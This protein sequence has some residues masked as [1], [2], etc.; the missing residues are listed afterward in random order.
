MLSAVRVVNA[1]FT[2]K[3]VTKG[4]ANPPSASLKAADYSLA[5][6]RTVARPK[7]KREALRHLSKR[8][9][10]ANDIAIIAGSDLDE[11]YITNI[12]FGNQN[13][14]AIVDTGSSDSWLAKKGF[15]CFTLAD[16]PEPEAECAFGTDGFDPDASPT[17]VAYPGHNFNISYGD[18]EFLT[19]EVGFETVA[20]GG[21][22]V[23]SQEVGIVTDAAWFGDGES[24]GLIGLCYPDLTSVYSTT[25]PSD[26]SAANNEPYD[27]FVFSAIKQGLISDP[28]FSVA[29]NRGS[30]AA[31]E[32][33][34]LDPNLGLLA[35]GGIAPVDVTNKAVTV[36]IQGF[37]VSSTKSDFFFYNV[38]IDAYVFPGS[39]A[40]QTSGTS[41][42]D[43]GTTLLYLP[44]PIADALAAE[45]VPPAVFSEDFGAYLVECN[46]T[47]PSFAVVIGSVSFSVTAADL[48][49]PIGA[50]SDGNQICISGHDDGGPQTGDNIF[51]LGD[52]FLHNVVATFNLADNVVTLTERT[53]Y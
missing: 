28:I 2:T 45:F 22:T 31:E 35:F 51:I 16:E 10:A 48:I 12:T 27:P 3:H 32:G 26:D 17:F 53:P 7:S 40:L 9:V 36:P 29:L 24:T 46:A 33:S 52:T 47:A 38:D 11:E 21:L 18:G 6:T 42:L 34:Q 5:L 13:F 50:D 15:S 37:A 30:V 14:T 20:I 19:G 8:V 41:I 25:N 49:L 39:E 4:A 1:A 44:T 43:T 23:T